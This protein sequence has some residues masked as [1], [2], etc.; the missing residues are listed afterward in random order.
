MRT[1][2]KVA[3][4]DGD[5]HPVKMNSIIEIDNSGQ[6][7]E[8]LVDGVRQGLGKYTE[9]P[10]HNVIEVGELRL[11]IHPQ[12]KIHYGAKHKEVQGDKSTKG[13]VTIVQPVGTWAA[14][15]QNL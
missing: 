13:R 5:P 2:W 9:S 4:L 3:F 12:D 15:A 8:V 7:P 14:E 1:K 10:S 6:I 11:T